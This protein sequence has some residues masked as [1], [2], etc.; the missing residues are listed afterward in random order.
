MNSNE[1]NRI[2]LFNKIEKKEKKARKRIFIYTL[3]PVIV[4]IVLIWVTSS[5]VINSKRELDK[6]QNE[7][8]IKI[9]ELE[10]I[11]SKVDTLDSKLS[12][13]VSSISEIIST[14][15]RIEDFIESKQSFLRSIDE[16]RFLINIRMLFDEINS[17]YSD[18][19][20]SSSKM[21]EL[22]RGRI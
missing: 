18:V 5:E 8:N 10:K 22:D 2:E 12:N 14:S 3:I 13:T 1:K 4:A 21:P 11:K 17:Q 20:A 19:L 16:A 7:L 9:L 15:H 6:I